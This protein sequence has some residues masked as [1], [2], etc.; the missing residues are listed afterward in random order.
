MNGGASGSTRWRRWWWSCANELLHN[1]M[2]A[3]VSELGG[4]TAAT[5]ALWFHS[6]NTRASERKRVRA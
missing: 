3:A 1:G 4:A 2:V 6:A 5:A